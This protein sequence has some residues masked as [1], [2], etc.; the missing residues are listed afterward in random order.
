MLLLFSLQIASREIIYLFHKLIHVGDGPN[1]P[2]ITAETVA[3]EFMNFFNYLGSTVTKQVIL[4]KR[5]T[6]SEVLPQP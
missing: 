5:S 3:L 1:P 6:D 4:M 2:P